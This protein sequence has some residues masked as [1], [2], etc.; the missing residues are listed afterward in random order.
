MQIVYKWAEPRP[1][2]EF[3]YYLAWKHRHIAGALLKRFS[4]HVWPSRAY[5]RAF[6]LWADAVDRTKRYGRDIVLASPPRP[7]S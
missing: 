2:Y 6:S 7:H 5:Q 1:G 3:Q 4:W